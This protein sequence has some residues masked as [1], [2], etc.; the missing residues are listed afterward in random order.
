MRARAGVRPLP[1]LATRATLVGAGVIHGLFSS[2]GPLLVWAIGRAPIEKSVFRAT[3][4]TLWVLLASA[5]TAA[6]A[7]NGRV[8]RESLAA[9]ASLLPVLAVSYAA[10]QWAHQ[11]LDETRFRTAVYLLLLAAGL[12]NAL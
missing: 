1:P 8:G 9:T 12:A 4:S 11:R 2:G 5:L 6:Y 10:G 7:W 3:L